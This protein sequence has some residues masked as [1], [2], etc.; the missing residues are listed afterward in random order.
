[1][2]RD[3][4]KMLS[5]AR[6][7]GRRYGLKCLMES[8]RLQGLL[9][10]R[11]DE[12]GRW[13]LPVQYVLGS[14]AALEYCKMFVE[15]GGSAGNIVSSGNACM[16]YLRKELLLTREGAEGIDAFFMEYL[17]GCRQTGMRQESPKYHL[18]A[19][20]CDVCVMD[21]EV[22]ADAGDWEQACRSLD[23]MGVECVAVLPAYLLTDGEK[24][25]EH[26]EIL[27]KMR[28]L[29]D[30]GCL[31]IRVDRP[32]SAENS[33]ENC[34][35]NCAESDEKISRLLR[36][37]EKYQKYDAETVAGLWIRRDVSEKQSIQ[38]MNGWKNK[39]VH[40]Y[41]SIPGEDMSFCKVI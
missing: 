3:N 20:E 27:R 36:E 16:F 41:L 33:T 19:E 29:A 1:M 14:P 8:Y 25:A 18:I 7:L 9:Q 30:E 17:E 15:S 28:E 35:K 38:K 5:C 12:M 10:D 39:K 11:K 2:E 4:H 23:S 6:E 13:L 32:N 21:W 31:W 40:V 24:M 34:V 26:G 22:F 37:A